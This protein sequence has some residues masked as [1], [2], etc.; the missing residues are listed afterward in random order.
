MQILKWILIL[1][2]VG[3]LVAAAVAPIGPV[4]GV[5]AGGDASAV[6]DSW[7]DTST[8][9]EIELQVGEGPVGRI[10]TI[11]TA[12]VDGNLYVTGSKDSGWVRGVGAGGPVRVWLNNK[13]YDLAATPVVGAEAVAALTGWHAKY[14]K[15][16]PDMMS[17]FPSPEEGAQVAVVYKLTERS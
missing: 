15:H 17:E 14:V 4:P 12:Q 2:V 9:L 10:V 1:V 6:P 13:L 16:Y 3:L 5:Y 7:G 11:W 8:A